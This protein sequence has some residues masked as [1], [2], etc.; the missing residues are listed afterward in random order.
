M[1]GLQPSDKHVE[2]LHSSPGL[3]VL[4]RGASPHPFLLEFSPCSWLG[5][6]L[7]PGL[8]DRHPGPGPDARY[9]EMNKECLSQDPPQCLLNEYFIHSLGISFSRKSWAL[10]H[11]QSVRLSPGISFL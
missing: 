5:A 2:E 8:S 3:M 7:P 4:T 9:S 10:V 6:V 1:S 11:V